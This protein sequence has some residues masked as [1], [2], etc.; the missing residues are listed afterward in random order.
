MLFIIRDRI[1]NQE[2]IEGIS[3]ASDVEVIYKG[4]WQDL[5]QRWGLTPDH[6]GGL[7]WTDVNES[8][9]EEPILLFDPALKESN[10]YSLLALA[11]GKELVEFVQN[12]FKDVPLTDRITLISKLDKLLLILNGP[13][14]NP[15][16]TQDSIDIDTIIN[17]S[18]ELASEEKTLLKSL[19]YNYLQN[20]RLA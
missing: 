1:G 2:A 9:D 14:M 7:Y 5:Y 4:S 12:Y 18:N 15:L 11:Q 10:N 17:A 6:V 13:T 3:V 8:K 19:K 16:S 20:R